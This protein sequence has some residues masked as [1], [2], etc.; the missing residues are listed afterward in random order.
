MK[1][2]VILAFLLGVGSLAPPVDLDEAEFLNFL[3]KHNKEHKNKEEYGKRLGIFKKNLKHIKDWNDKE[4][5][6]KGWKKG[7]TKFADWTD[8]EYQ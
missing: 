8:E 1:K 3:A 4:A 7:I 6:D 2:I 5:T